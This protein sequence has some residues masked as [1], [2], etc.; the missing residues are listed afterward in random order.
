MRAR[1][2]VHQTNRLPSIAVNTCL[3]IAVLLL[4]IL[5]IQ[6]LLHN[7]TYTEYLLVLD[8]WRFFN[9]VYSDADLL[10]YFFHNVHTFAVPSFILYLDVLFSNGSLQFQHYF[11]SVVTLAI[12]VGFLIVSSKQDGLFADKW[13]SACIL[14]LFM[15]SMWLSPSNARAYT[16]PLLDTISSVS[17]LSIVLAA[18][19]YLKL[20]ASAGSG[21]SRSVYLLLLVLI[22]YVGFLTLE[23]FVVTLFAL[24]CD[25]FIRK[26][27]SLGS[28]LSIVAL[29]CLLLYAA[30]HNHPLADSS[31]SHEIDLT[32]SIVNFMILLSSQV[33]FLVS[34]LGWG[35]QMAISISIAF[36]LVSMVFIV[37][38]LSYLAV[39]I[40]K[41]DFWFV[42]PLLLILFSTFSLTSAVWLRF[43][44]AAI[45][46]AIPRYTP[47]AVMYAMGVT[48]ISY[49]FMARTN[50]RFFRLASLLV[51]G[52]Y[53]IATSLDAWAMYFRDHNMGRF[54]IDA[55]LEMPVYA[56]NPGDEI[57]LG[58]VAPNKGLQYRNKLHSFLETNE[59]SVF[60]SLPYL[61]LNTQI[62]SVQE[63]SNKACVAISHKRVVRK[64]NQYSLVE[65]RLADPHGRG[66]FLVLDEDTNLL[67]FSFPSRTTPFSQ[68]VTGVF[69]LDRKDKSTIHYLR[70]RDDY[71]PSSRLYGCGPVQG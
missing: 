47:Y 4:G 50:N 9:K 53:L 66:V 22:S 3:L 44:D 13:L 35:K 69:R 31:V 49:W 14:S 29:S 71:H 48:M 46:S 43:S 25:A 28:L 21:A 55:R 51:F 10:N 59:L 70:N 41:I 5:F 54:F 20:A 64:L 65:F 68:Y 6:L 16:Y 8:S 30:F 42:L 11:V 32:A 12:F 7:Q 15:L 61:K 57:D 60:S 45:D 52:L 27:H 1:P 36:S 2:I 34:G 18:I 39:R 67:G 26:N 58:P 38:V 62:S 63:P 24:A 56:Q 33:H 17:L 23:T 40:R 37:A 19:T